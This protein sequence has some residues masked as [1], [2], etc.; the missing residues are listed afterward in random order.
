M[1]SIH[2]HVFRTV[3][4]EWVV[5]ECLKIIWP[6][7]RLR[8]TF[9]GGIQAYYCLLS[10]RSDLE[11]CLWSWSMPSAVETTNGEGQMADQCQITQEPV[12]G[13]ALT[14]LCDCQ[15]ESLHQTLW[16]QLL[17]FVWKWNASQKVHENPL[18]CCTNDPHGNH[19]VL[20]DKYISL[21]MQIWHGIVQC[22]ASHNAT[23]GPQFLPLG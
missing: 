10:Q 5:G 17:D 12:M 4:L 14:C 1:L 16:Q 11:P 15:G 22:S 18:P 2:H 8:M 3:R 9:H 13:S 23:V 19:Q 6:L 20:L 7:K 21:M